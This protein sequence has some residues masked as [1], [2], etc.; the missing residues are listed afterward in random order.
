[1]E[2][3]FLEPIFLLLLVAVPLLWTAMRPLTRIW[4]ALWTRIA[5]LGARSA[6]KRQREPAKGGVNGISR[7]RALGWFLPRRASN[8][9]LAIL[10][11]LVFVCIVIALSRP[12]IVTPDDVT[13]Q[14]LVLDYSQSISSAQRARQQR[15]ATRLLQQVANRTRSSIVTIGGDTADVG[16]ALNGVG[17]AIHVRDQQSPSSISAALAAAAQQVPDGARGVISLFSDGLATDRR[18]APTVQSL[19]A[20]GIRVD[21]YDL[22]RDERDVYPVGVRADPIVRVGQTA[23]LDVDLVGVAKGVHVRLLGEG[24]DAIAESGPVESDE[25]VTVPL[26]FEPKSAGFLRVTARVIVPGAQDSNPRNN[27]LGHTLAIQDATRVLYLGDR[28]R[29]G[30]DRLAELLGRGFDVV[31]ASRQVLH[32]GVDLGAYS[33][34]VVD[35]IPARKLP[36]AFQ[37]HVVE[38]VRTHGLGLLFSGG[39]SAFGMG[40][41]DQTA[42]ATILPVDFTQR[43]EKRDPSTSL[44]IVMDTSGSMAGTRIELAKQVARLAIR[45]LKAHDRIGIVEFY[46]NKHWALP[47]QSAAN[48]ITVDRAIGRMQ[49]IGGTV[50]M[51][52]IEEAYYGLKNVDTRY[53]HLLIITDAGIEE[54]GYE[55]MLRLVTKDGVNVSTVLVGAQG[56]NQLM[57]DM[58]S[59]GRGRFYSA[60]D[61]YS[62]P[63]LILKQPSTMNLPAYR[64]G[65]FVVLGRGGEG[66]WSNI[67]RRTMPPLSGYV[68]TTSRPGAEVLI[69]VQENAHPILATWRYGLGRVTSFMTEPVGEGTRSWDRWD[70]YGRLLARIVARSADD[71]EPFH[72]D[73][74]R[75]DHELTVSAHRDSVDTALY[76]H[77]VFVDPRVASPS[78]CASV[79]S[80]QGTSRRASPHVPQPISACWQQRGV[81]ARRSARVTRCDSS[82]WRPTRCHRS[83]RWTRSRAWISPRWRPRQAAHLSARSPSPVVCPLML[84]AIPTRVDRR[85]RSLSSGCGPCCSCLDCSCTW[86]S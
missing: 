51:P 34:A 1:M 10:R 55:A 46:G 79:N 27:E 32:S 49:A 70:D 9:M 43:T 45:R 58:A 47:L 77:A 31:D 36:A 2:L 83:F 67:N 72:Y 44:A 65:T 63:E 21:T 86:P 26:E 84:R 69:E 54:A 42:L 52:A 33:L 75:V 28:V 71:K 50:L 30:A 6:P 3:T 5:V 68:E 64:A 57:I 40:G 59:W 73:L 19:I 78:L 16:D 7:A 76:P 17:A 38:A 14:I 60:V 62:L 22:G 8:R 29:N 4:Y 15:V 74:H 20:R 53:K 18:W 61:R 56:H 81:R 12:V 41:Y 24:G 13:Y 35:D 48:K 82:R 85:R 25:R 23:H 37:R 66:W 80:R 11:T 39:K